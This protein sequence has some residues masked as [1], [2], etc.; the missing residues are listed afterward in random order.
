M[1]TYILFI[2]TLL[3]SAIAVAQNI[4]YAEYFVDSD[5]GFGS[6][7][8]ISVASPSNDLTLNLA[9]STN[10]LA[11]GWHKLGMRALNDMGQWS[12]L[13]GKMFYIFKLPVG[14][15][16]NVHEI[17]YFFDTDP[18]FG[19]G[20]MVAVANP[21]QDLDISFNANVSALGSGEHVLYL[22]AKNA[23]GQWGQ[24]Y[25]EAFN[26]TVTG[27]DE[28]VTSVFRVY[29]NPGR[30][31]FTIDVPVRNN[32]PYTLKIRNLNGVTVAEK[33]CSGEEVKISLTLG[34][35]IYV[36]EID[37]GEQNYLQKLSIY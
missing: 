11:P 28:E 32:K 8:A 24:V 14:S 22:R 5:P 27:L 10:T 17:E 20:T 1:R 33:T 36:V 31:D 34:K 26:R 12:V 18:G 23:I 30:Y 9:V 16:A 4:T 7:S 6:A 13:C 25:A 2:M 15:Q 3:G 37:T 29:P 19:N 35:G 21:G